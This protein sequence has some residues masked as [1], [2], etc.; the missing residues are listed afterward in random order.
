MNGTHG[1]PQLHPTATLPGTDVLQHHVSKAMW[2]LEKEM[3]SL[4]FT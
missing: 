2:Q 1:I 3:P 4:S